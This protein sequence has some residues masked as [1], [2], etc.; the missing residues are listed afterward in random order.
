VC[1]CA[2]DFAWLIRTFHLSGT[3]FYRRPL[4]DLRSG[5]A[6]RVRTWQ[7]AVNRGPQTLF[8]CL[9]CRYGLTHMAALWQTL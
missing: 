1:A 3:W 4:G 7:N 5:R 2:L 6:A 9:R 8:A